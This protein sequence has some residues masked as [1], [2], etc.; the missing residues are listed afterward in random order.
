MAAA[1]IL[2]EEDRV[3]LLDGEIV[4]MSPIGPRHA[5]TVNRL[6]RLFTKSLGDLATVS[7]Q[8]P[9]LLSRTGEPQPDVTIL[10]FRED[11]YGARLPEPRDVLLLIE[12]ADSSAAV[13]RH[14]KLRLYA[15]AGVGEYWIVH[16]PGDRIEVYRDPSNGRYA[17]HQ[18]VSRGATLAPQRFPNV[19][20]AA[21]EI[22]GP[23]ETPHLD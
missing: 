17:T 13:D 9:V 18:T 11:G 2:T 19:V 16:L 7:V 15:E 21:A 8:N 1:G 10:A 20:L 14:L 6:T 12:V 3:E 22:L 5:G 23:S 4:E